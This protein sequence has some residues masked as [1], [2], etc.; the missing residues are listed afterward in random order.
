MRQLAVIA[1]V[2]VTALGGVAAVFAYECSMSSCLGFSP[3][4]SE[5]LTLQSYT[6]GYGAGQSSPSVLTLLVENSGTSTAVLSF[7]TIKD[8]TTGSGPVSFPISVSIPSHST[9]TVTVD[10]SSAN[11]FFVHGHDY[12][13]G[14]TTSRNQFGFSF[15][16]A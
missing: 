6:V 11:F 9:G 10:T 3:F 12:N 1:L 14:T 2:S 4:P 8:M 5:S 15:S 16:Y 13:V 7:L